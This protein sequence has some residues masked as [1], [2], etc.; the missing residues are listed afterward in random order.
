MSDSAGLHEDGAV[1]QPLQIPALPHTNPEAPFAFVEVSSHLRGGGRN[2]RSIV[3]DLNYLYHA[4]VFD[5][6]EGAGTLCI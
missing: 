5:S 3:E 1:T 4:P 2:Q 6:R